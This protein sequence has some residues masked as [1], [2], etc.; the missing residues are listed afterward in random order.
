MSTGRW[1]PT[2]GATPI[3]NF[4]ATWISPSSLQCWINMR[5]TSREPTFWAILSKVRQ[6]CRTPDAMGGLLLRFLPACDHD[7][8]GPEETPVKSVKR[9]ATRLLK[10]FSKGNEMRRRRT[11]VSCWHANSG[12][13][14]ALWRLYCSPPAGGVAIQTTAGLLSDAL[15]VDENLEVE[16]GRVQYVD[17][18][19]RFAGINDQIFWKRKWLSHEAEVRAIIYRSPTNDQLGFA[20]PVDLE[21]TIVSVV[22]SSFAPSWFAEVVASVVK[23]YE[24]NI[25]IKESELLL[26]PFFQKRNS[27]YSLPSAS[28]CRARAL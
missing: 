27:A 19:Q 16:L 18:R 17:F 2:N 12:E 22:T 9:E 15:G 24:L 23:K 8:A 11:F 26:E 6:A 5:F 28:A 1:K 14:E 25:S 13:S 4:G 10:E 3:R 21:K 20:I 7:R